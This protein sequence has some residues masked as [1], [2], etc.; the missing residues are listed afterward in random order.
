MLKED[1]ITPGNTCEEAVI[2]LLQRIDVSS[3]ENPSDLNSSRPALSR[4]VDG[5]H[6]IPLD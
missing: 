5:S 1:N 6:D 4:V 3:V 2:T